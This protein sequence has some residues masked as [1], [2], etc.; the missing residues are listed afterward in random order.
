MRRKLL[1]KRRKPALWGTAEAPDGVFT[2]AIN[3]TSAVS[4]ALITSATVYL[5]S[6]VVV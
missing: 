2:F 1:R 4:T 5:D 6:I 3:V